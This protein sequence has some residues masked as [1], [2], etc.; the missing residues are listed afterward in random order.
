[1]LPVIYCIC[2]NFVLLSCL[3]CWILGVV[4]AL[5]RGAA[6]GLYMKLRV[7][8]FFYFLFFL[9]YCWRQKILFQISNDTHTFFK[10]V[11]TFTVAA[12]L[13]FVHSCDLF[14]SCIFT[15]T[16]RTTAV[17]M[18]EKVADW[19]FWLII[20]FHARV[21]CFNN[22]HRLYFKY[23]SKG[24]L[25]SKMTPILLDYYYWRIHM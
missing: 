15:V 10:E 1:M 18:N 6:E 23:K 20:T 4:Q 3:R 8:C 13:W 16:A 11:V 14:M 12:V 24:L 9:S 7:H 5:C 21:Y 17:Y 22:I 25:S 19:A 2:D